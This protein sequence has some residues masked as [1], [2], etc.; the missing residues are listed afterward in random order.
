[1][2]TWRERAACNA[3]TVN[4]EWF[5]PDLPGLAGNKAKAICKGCTV[6]K[7]CLD[8]A[9]WEPVC[10]IWGGTTKAER[11]AMRRALG[12]PLPSGWSARTQMTRW[13]QRYHELRELGYSDFD[14]VRK[15]GVKPQSLMRQL[16]RYGIKAS[17]QLQELVQEKKR[18]S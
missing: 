17:H 5:F 6:T 15:L 9:L 2:S 18:P 7:Q 4:P 3:D 11:V 16:N 13:E 14:I 1:M 8:A 10:G 12:M